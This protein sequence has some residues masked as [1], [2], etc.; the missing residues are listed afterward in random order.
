MPAIVN[1]RCSWYIFCSDCR[2]VQRGSLPGKRQRTCSVDLGRDTGAYLPTRDRPPRAGYWTVNAA[3]RLPHPTR[4]NSL[5][6]LQHTSS[7]ING[8][9]CFLTVSGLISFLTVS[10]FAFGIF[11]HFVEKRPDFVYLFSTSVSVLVLLLP[12]CINIQ[13]DTVT[14]RWCSPDRVTF[15]LVQW[16]LTVDDVLDN[17]YRVSD[18]NDLS[19]IIRR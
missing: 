17:G 15:S 1:L 11:V 13:L 12:W 19:L 14:C 7:L 16:I 4:H 10:G 5:P 2:L 8:L 18:T 9:V 6:G 3:D